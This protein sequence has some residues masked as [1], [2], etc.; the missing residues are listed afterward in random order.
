MCWI[1]W[2]P[3]ILYID[4]ISPNFSSKIWLTIYFNG[5]PSEKYS[6]GWKLKILNTKFDDLEAWGIKPEKWIYFGYEK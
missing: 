2:W 6:S 1:K 3:D 5:Q 4:K